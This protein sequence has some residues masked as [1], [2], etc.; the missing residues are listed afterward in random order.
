MRKPF[1]D[2]PDR[3][4]IRTKIMGLGERAGRKS[5]Y[6][7]LQAHIRELEENKAF[8]EAKS[9]A[10][11]GMLEELDSARRRAEESERRFRDLTDLLP[12]T[13]FEIDCT[14]RVTFAN[15]IAFEMFGYLPEEIE[16]GLDCF[17]MLAPEDRDRARANVERTLSGDDLRGQQYTALRKDGGT[18]QCL[19][20]TTAVHDSTGVTGLRGIVVDI[21]EQV[22]LREQKDLI[23]AQYHQAQKMEAVGRLA[24]GVAHDFNNLICPIL[25]YSEMLLDNFSVDDARRQSVETIHRAGLKARDVVRQL[26]AFSRKQTLEVKVVDLNKVISGFETLVRRMVRDDI[27]IR[28][29]LSARVVSVQ[30][31]VGQI[32]QVIMNLVVNAQDAMP[33]GGRIT[34]ETGA[35]YLEDTCTP[36]HHVM[37]PG[38]FAVLTVSDT[39]HGMDGGTREHIFDPFFTTKE[40]GK[41]TGLGL[42]TVYGIIMQHRGN[43]RVVSEPGEG[44]TFKVYLPMV[45][46]DVVDSK[47]TAQ[48]TAQNG[49]SETVLVA[50]DS[51]MVRNLTVRILELQGYKVLSG[52]NAAE[53][54]ALLDRHEGPVDLLITDVVM[55]DMN[56]KELSQRVAVRCPGIRVLYM[57]GYTEEVIV[58]HG[59]LEKGIAFIQ[60]PFTVQRFA[61]KVREVLED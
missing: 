61:A 10:L 13:V 47:A 16:R 38:S 57:S 52:A 45:N 19:I 21:T 17:E 8:L 34:I 37:Q 9:A 15:R 3:G 56:G 11:S 50:E 25:G 58:H 39:G 35:A 48:V 54:L 20:Y 49:G 1:D 53:C 29:S 31:D 46:G 42:A 4:H 41:G 27:E 7:Q 30:A 23:E 14:G 32:E 12:Q 55:C 60:K 51:D 36:G 5:Y 18:F 26:L 44:A 28:L 24:G 2:Q 33:D 43:I 6:P 59:V 22:G 40:K